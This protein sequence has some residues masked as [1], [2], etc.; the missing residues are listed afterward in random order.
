MFERVEEVL[1]VEKARWS[2]GTLG[3]RSNSGSFRN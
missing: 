1:V 3:F 2:Y